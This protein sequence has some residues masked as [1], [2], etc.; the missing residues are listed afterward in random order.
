MNEH[1]ESFLRIFNKKV[2]ELEV[3]LGI[4]RASDLQ[5]QACTDV[6]ELLKKIHSEKQKAIQSA[7]EDYANLLL[8]CE[9]AA[10]AVLA[11]LQMWLLLKEDRPDDAWDELISAQG[12]C[13][14]A[15]RAHSCFANLHKYYEHL[16]VIEH[17]VFP[18]QVFVST[19]FIVRNQECS[20]CGMEYEECDH[21]IGKPYMGKFCYIIAREAEPNHVAF[22]DYPADKRCRLTSFG[23]EGGNRNRMTWLVTPD[24]NAAH[25]NHELT[26]EVKIASE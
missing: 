16:E 1:Q 25:P 10:S 4:T 2:S 19:G 9:C 20:I 12:A 22:V 26:A 14:G 18:P 6:E 11:E 24:K 23:V 8:G 13:L 15:S 3:Y 21:L 5:R 7:D 17:I